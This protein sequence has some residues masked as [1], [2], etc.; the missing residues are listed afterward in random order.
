[1]EGHH[2]FS[3]AMAIALSSNSN[4]LLRT[5]ISSAIISSGQGKGVVRVAEGNGGEITNTFFQMCHQSLAL[6]SLSPCRRPRGQRL[7][8]R[9]HPRW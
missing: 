9:P 5:F 8:P 6:H 7:L 4:S 2:S 3:F 1:L